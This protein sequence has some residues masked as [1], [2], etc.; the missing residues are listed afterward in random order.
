MAFIDS[1]KTFDK[2]EHH[3]EMK[4]IAI[5]KDISP[6]LLRIPSPLYKKVKLKLVEDQKKLRGI[7][8]EMLEEYIKK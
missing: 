4:E 5:N 3:A 8:V 2:N 1:G 7:L 6:Y